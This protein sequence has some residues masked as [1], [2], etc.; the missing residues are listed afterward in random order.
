M[1]KFLLVSVVI[2]LLSSSSFSQVNILLNGGF[3][4]WT[5]AFP[6]DWSINSSFVKDSLIV[7]SGSYSLRM[8]GPASSNRYARQ[9]VNVTP[10]VT[11]TFK[12]Y[13]FDNDPN[14]SV[15]VWHRFRDA[16]STILATISSDYTVDDPN[17]QYIEVQGEAP[18]TA[19]LVQFEVRA[20]NGG[21]TGGGFAYLDDCELV[22]PNANAPLI[23]N[24]A[25]EPFPANQSI[26]ITCDVTVSTGAVDSV[27]LYY[28]TDFNPTSVDSL[29]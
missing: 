29:P 10:G 23:T 1:K 6:D 19:V 16:S 28:Y 4:A 5:G 13:V 27:A 18:P 8:E 17:W 26:D 25:Y 3:E 14:V 21:G 24:V 20:Y 9:E 15:R 2:F 7:H 22:A 12:S 11:Y